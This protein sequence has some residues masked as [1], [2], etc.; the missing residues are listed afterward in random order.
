MKNYDEHI[1]FLQLLVQTNSANPL[2]PEKSIPEKPIEKEIAHLIR[3]KLLEIGLQPEFKGVSPHR[4]NVIARLKGNRSLRSLIL[5]GHMDT[6]MPSQ[7]SRN[8]PFKGEIKGNRLYGL[9]ALDMKA[10]LSIFIFAAKALLEC[11]VRLLGDLI[12]TFVVDEEP[13]A[14]SN[15]GTK[16]L[17]K[18]GLTGT[19]AVVAEPG[20]GNV[21]TG[22]RGGYRFKLTTQGEATHTGFAA[23]ER[24]KKGKNAIVDM[25]RAI[26][27][28]SKI[29]IP[30][31]ET[32]TFPGRKPVFTFPTLIQGG[33]SINVVP[34]LCTAY[35]DVRLLP[36][37]SEEVVEKLIMD[38]LDSVPNLEYEL[39]KILYVPPVEISSD[40]EIVKVF[41]ARTT[42][43]VQKEPSTIGCG[44]WNDGWMFITKGIPAI[45]GFG[46]E[47]HG[48]HAPDEYVYT[49]SVIETTRIYVRA[50]V[51]YLGVAS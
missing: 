51:D 18:T 46:P 43:I 40:E 2:T 17:L 10:S 23:W 50:I 14:C 36:G 8:D 21:T 11:N 32:P 47:G 38:Q 30:Y 5:N 48:V 4:P 49:D 34:D 20:N 27:A 13:G 45:C 39:T 28:L 25:A 41:K 31:R 19:A 42:E 29:E 15:Y 33:T 24:E 9:G 1:S 44:P 26:D 22:H 3:N 35:G 7:L 16:Y 12:L 37:N 6:V